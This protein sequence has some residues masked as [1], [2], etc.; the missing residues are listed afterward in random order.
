MGIDRDLAES[1]AWA[2]GHTP[3]PWE[4]RHTYMDDLFV[5]EDDPSA[6][7]RSAVWVLTCT[8]C[9]AQLADDRALAA[10]SGLLTDWCPW[11]LIMIPERRMEAAARYRAWWQSLGYEAALWSGDDTPPP[12]PAALLGG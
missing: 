10:Q 3:G 2:L 4:R 12:R 5:R 7:G 1:F 9:G 8:R 11:L 6:A